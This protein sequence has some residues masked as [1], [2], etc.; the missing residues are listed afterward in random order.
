MAT[1]L[2][3]STD[4]LSGE[5]D[6]AILEGF[7]TRVALD[8]AAAYNGVLVY[9]GDRLGIWR[10][11]ASGGRFTSSQLAER[12]GLAERYVREWLSTQAAGGY[13]EYDAADRTFSLPLEHGLVLADEDNPASGIAGFEVISA[14]WAAADQLAH[15][16]VT[17]EGVGWHEHDSRLYSGVD[18]FFATQ[19]RSSLVQEW[20]PAVEGLDEQLES[21]IR[22]LDVGCGLGSAGILMAEAYP[23]ST[24]KGVDYHDESIRRAIAAAAEAGVGD[25]VEFERDDA[26]SYDGTF[27]LICFF[28]AVH[29]LG[30]PVGALTHAREH[31]APGGRVFAVEPYAEDALEA[32]VG[33]PVALMY[34]AAS[35]C[36]C[37]PNSISQGGEALGAQAGPA[38]LLAAFR[39]A[40]FSHAE[41]AAQTPYNLLIEARA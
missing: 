22:V 2:T 5:P 14:V 10:E 35:S 23:R 26:K 17:G 15:A 30:D 21:G 32:G 31:L 3:E 8:R 34:Y 18:R 11:L 36:L 13:V 9:L 6:L 24:F 7:A 39:D 38:K 37:V 16:Y 29:D 33:S 20:I 41:V 27:D 4:Q 25:R 12:C 1:T 40:G 19:Y 28:D